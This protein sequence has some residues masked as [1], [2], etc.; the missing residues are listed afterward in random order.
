MSTSDQRVARSGRT[1]EASKAIAPRSQ[2]LRLVLE[3]LRSHA[4]LTEP[5]GASGDHHR[6]DFSADEGVRS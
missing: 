1:W 4:R 2:R 6:P 3:H 5:A